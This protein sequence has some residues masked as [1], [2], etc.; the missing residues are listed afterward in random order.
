MKK[1]LNNYAFAVWLLAVGYALLMIPEVVELFRQPSLLESHYSA[2]YVE[3]FQIR[4]IFGLLRNTVLGSGTLLALGT[5]IELVDRIVW[6][7]RTR[8]FS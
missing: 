2:N 8:V 7:A 1:P 3:S 4:D 6:E 5:I